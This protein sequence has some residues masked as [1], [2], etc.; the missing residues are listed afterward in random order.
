MEPG[1]GET[2]KTDDERGD[3]VLRVMVARPGLL[4]GEKAGEGLCRLHPVDHC[5]DDQSDPH[6]DRGDCQPPTFRQ[7]LPPSLAC[8]REP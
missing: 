8:A 4:T 7:R 1:E 6:H 2:G 5:D 3:A